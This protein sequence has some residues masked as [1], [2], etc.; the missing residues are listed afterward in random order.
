M[1]QQNEQKLILY[2]DLADLDESMKKMDSLNQLLM[3]PSRQ[4]WIKEHPFI[5]K[6]NGDKLQYL[7]IDKVRLLM[8]LIFQRTRRE[9][10]EVKQV[11]N[12]VVA[13]VR[14]HYFNPVLK[15][16]EWQDGTGAVQIQL[17]KGAPAFDL[18]QI[19]SNAIQMGAP[20][21]VSYAYKNACEEIGNIFGASIQKDY[22]EFKGM[23]A[24]AIEQN[25]TPQPT[26]QPDTITTNF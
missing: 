17:K 26:Q 3:K 9:I 22:V 6:E 23:Y 12:S 2:S 20:A 24:A 7:P 4:D 1:E 25:E 5:K 16:W 21:A 14:V 11:A 15:E 8:R 13:V 19:N 10:K 18:T